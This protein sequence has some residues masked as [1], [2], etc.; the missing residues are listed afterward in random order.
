LEEAQMLKTKAMRENEE[1]RYAKNF[2]YSLIRIRFPDGLYL[3]ANITKLYNF[4]SYLTNKCL[5]PFSQGTFGAHEK[6][7][8]VFDFVQSALCHESAEFSL[9]SPDGQKFSN[10][11]ASQSLVDLK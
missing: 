3:Q 10:E 9:I 2:K 4:I 8:N 5:N 1:K 11:D 7:S 6:L